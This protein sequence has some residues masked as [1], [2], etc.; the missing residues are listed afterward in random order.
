MKRIVEG[1]GLGIAAILFVLAFSPLAAALGVVI[2][3]SIR[4]FQHSRQKVT[5]GTCSECEKAIEFATG[6]VGA[7][8]PCPFCGKATLLVAAASQKPMWPAWKIGA[9]SGVVSVIASVCIA[10]VL[11][12]E[13]PKASAFKVTQTKSLS[14]PPLERFDDSI[15]YSPDVQNYPGTVVTST[16][17][18]TLQEMQ[19]RA[20]MYERLHR[21][22]WD[23]QIALQQERNRQI[24]LQNEQQQWKRMSAPL[25]E[26]P[27]CRPHRVRF[28]VD[29]EIA[30]LS[31]GLPPW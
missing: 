22:Y 27:P 12:P 7:K 3:M 26:S 6:A 2:Y 23:A 5:V 16:P 19:L 28:C 25:L 11:N 29:C 9:F 15:R 21:Q 18:V 13:P 8:G 1:F 31:A 10:L 17:V 24:N 30:K 14:R 20:Q 4:A